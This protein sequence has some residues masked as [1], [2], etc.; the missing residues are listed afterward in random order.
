MSI[1][2]FIC[3]FEDVA[4]FVL[5]NCQNISDLVLWQGFSFANKNEG[6]RYLNN[7]LSEA[8]NINLGTTT[9][10]QPAMQNIIT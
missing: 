1:H 2:S 9:T 3:D 6:H 8:N 5:L 7:L 10:L 4:L